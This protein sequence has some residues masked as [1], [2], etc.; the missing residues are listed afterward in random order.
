MSFCWLSVFAISVFTVPFFVEASDESVDD[1]NDRGC[2]YRSGDNAQQAFDYFKENTHFLSL[3]HSNEGLC[4]G[5]ACAWLQAV[6]D[7]PDSRSRLKLRLETCSRNSKQGWRYQGQ[8]YNSLQEELQAAQQRYD[9]YRTAYASP[10]NPETLKRFSEIDAESAERVETKVWVQW[11][12][13]EQQRQQGCSAKVTESDKALPRLTM[14]QAWPVVTTRASTVELLRTLRNQP[15]PAHYLL[16]SGKHAL[17]LTVEKDRLILFDQNAPCYIHETLPDN[18]DILASELFDALAIQPDCS[19]AIDHNGSVIRCGTLSAVQPVSSSIS[20]EAIEPIIENLMNNRV[21]VWTLQAVLPENVSEERKTEADWRTE[22]LVENLSKRFPVP[23]NTLDADGYSRLHL[24]SRLGNLES[25][26]T[27]LVE[28]EDPAF[29]SPEGLTAFDLACHHY[30]DIAKRLQQALQQQGIQPVCTPDKTGTFHPQLHKPWRP[31]QAPLPDDLVQAHRE[32]MQN[33]LPG[34]SVTVQGATTIRPLQDH[35]PV[36]GCSQAG[37]SWEDFKFRKALGTIGRGEDPVSR[38]VDRIEQVHDDI[39][40]FVTDHHPTLSAIMITSRE[41][42]GKLVAEQVDLLD[43]A[44]G[45]V[46]SQ[47]WSN[48]DQNLKDEFNG[49]LKVAAVMPGGKPIKSVTSNINPKNLIGRQT[50]AE[51]SESKVNSIRKKYRKAEGYNQIPID[52]AE[53]DGG[54]KIILDGHHRWQAA[55]REKLDEVPIKIHKVSK[56]QADGLL[57]EAAEAKLYEDH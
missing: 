32:I 29:Q 30:P 47:S 5:L 27:L 48:L 11:L 52:V 36:G 39:V 14:T 53:V 12:Y 46:I 4:L 6:L 49:L 28:G 7:Q 55:I 54:Q 57:K 44:T 31:A 15:A 42:Q 43:R 8:Y 3:T 50:P 16:S 56:E 2:L 22:W 21:A 34:S 24:A 1:S 13:R 17:A 45:R 18:S 33:R 20:W 40:G 51:M 35:C 26:E 41:V 9:A 25:V 38:F 23:A 37:S 10:D 19:T